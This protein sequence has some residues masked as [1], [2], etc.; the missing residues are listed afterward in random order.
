MG[1][2]QQTVNDPSVVCLPRSSG[3]PIIRVT[4]GPPGG[5]SAPADLRVLRGG[6]QASALACTSWV[7]GTVTVSGAAPGSA[8][9]DLVVGDLLDATPVAAAPAQV[10]PVPAGGKAV[11]DPSIAGSLLACYD[12]E[13]F[14][15]SGNFGVL[16]ATFPAPVATWP[17]R[18][19]NA[20]DLSAP[21]GHRP[22]LVIGRTGRPALR[23][24][25][26]ATATTYM[27]ETSIPVNTSG[28]AL[29]VVF[30]AFSRGTFGGTTIAGFSSVST[31]SQLLTFYE[32]IAQY[33]QVYTPGGLAYTP[34]GGD[35]FPDGMTV[36]V[37]T[38]VNSLMK[39][40]MN[41]VYM[42]SAT[43][44]GGVNFATTG[45]SLFW[46]NG[47][48][49]GLFA[50]AYLAAVYDAGLSDAD[51]L[52]LNQNLTYKYVPLINPAAPAY[53]PA[54]V[55]FTGDSRMWGF[56]A[57]CTDR[58]IPHQVMQKLGLAGVGSVNTAVPGS[59][60]AAVSAGL[61]ILPYA[62]AGR[63]AQVAVLLSGVNN[64]LGS[65]SAASIFPQIQTW[66]ANAR[67]A[68][69]KAVVCTPPPANGYTGPQL[70]EHNSL[71]ASI[72]AD[73]N[74][75]WDATADLNGSSTLVTAGVVNAP[76]IGPDGLHL[77]GAGNAICAGIIKAAVAPLVA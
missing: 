21:S 43:T 5:F 41:G 15:E 20:H 11:T 47:V 56:G 33:F 74:T 1:N 58:D 17:D 27:S 53:S 13:D 37:Y 2:H 12:T 48:G 70:T 39:C 4:G 71:C 61:D 18:T 36:I 65:Q 67:A 76:Y 63:Y 8:D 14:L 45:L 22:Y 44:N 50:D 9:L 24:A 77:L 68:G 57:E 55:A 32:G 69:F 66:A 23:F 64:L 3:A 46:N 52:A 19:T 38:F 75:H 16:G 31:I 40:W 62:N 59:G 25:N 54:F 42:G 29:A 26:T 28:M 73:G 6:S 7:G 49:Q 34:P 35:F 51:A 10:P 72:L 60:I 30:D